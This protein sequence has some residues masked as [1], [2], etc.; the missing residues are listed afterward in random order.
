MSHEKNELS[1]YHDSLF[2]RG[3][4]SNFFSDNFWDSFNFGNFKVDVRETND[5]YIIEAEMPGQNKNDISIHIHDNI[6]TIL[7]SMDEDNE[8]R[9]ESGRY[10][11]KERRSGSLKRSFSLENIKAEEVRAEMNNGILS[12]YCPKKEE[13]IS[14]TRKIEIQ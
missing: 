6:L 3:L 7:A 14:K 9:A 1:T 8:Q 10:L 11:R 2:P 4:L 5:T 13:S 12:V